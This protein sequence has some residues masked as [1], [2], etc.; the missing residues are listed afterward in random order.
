MKAV[1]YLLATHHRRPIVRAMSHYTSKTEIFYKP[2]RKYPALFE[3]GFLDEWVHPDLF[4]IKQDIEKYYQDHTEEMSTSESPLDEATAAKMSSKLHIEC[5]EVY[6]FD[7]LSDYFLNIMNEELKNFYELSEKYN[8]DVRRPNSMN[9][10]GV[11]LNEIGM[12][13]MIS[14][15]QQQYIWPLA[16]VLFPKEGQQFDDHH[17][18]IVRYQAD[19]DLGLDMHTDDSDGECVLRLILFCEILMG[20]NSTLPFSPIQ[21][22]SMFVSATRTLRVPLWSF[23]ACL[24]RQITDNLPIFIITRLAE[25]FCTWAIEDT[26][27]MTLP[28][29]HVSIGSCGITIGSIEAVKSTETVELSR[30]IPRKVGRLPMFVS[31]TLTTGI[32]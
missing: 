21:S 10:Y 25:P 29:A 14:A 11:I 28:V 13:P 1:F 8:V 16:R 17:S 6:S 12:R 27:R 5:K 26:V 32:T 30:R 24:G 4:E 3:N 18:F 19:E 2:F 9:N 22:H 7:C 15:L 23:A 20:C 31:A